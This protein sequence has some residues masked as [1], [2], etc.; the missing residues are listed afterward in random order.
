MPFGWQGIVQGASIVFFAYIGFD[1]VSTA[2]EE[3]KNPQKDLPRGIIASLIICTLLY[4]VVSA[5]LTGM[6][7][8]AKFN[9]TSA[10]VAYA[11]SQVGINWGSALVSV[12]AI[13]GITSV[14]LV[15]MF[16][17]TRVFFAMSRDGLLPKAF[18]DVHPKFKTPVKSTLLVAVVTA[19]L[20]GF[21][22]INLVAELTNIGTLAAF[23]IVS[24]SV[25][26]LRVKR[27]D[28]KRSFKCP[29][30]P[31]IPSL[32][33]IFC[34]GLIIALPTVTHI[35]FIVWMLIGIVIYFGYGVKHSAISEIKK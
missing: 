35:R 24:A 33:I 26:V 4:I 18:G 32:A 6:V 1:S 27:P 11:L 2:A 29:W 9:E 30:V 5:V 25:I 15:M 34:I 8:Y 12:G 20:A 7:P 21:L 19:V 16:G 10:P 23:L 22:P 17:Q 3:V 28:I 14:L 13:C 31:V